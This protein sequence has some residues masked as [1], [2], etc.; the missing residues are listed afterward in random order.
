M[1]AG[2][3]LCIPVVDHVIVTRNADRYHSMFE[4]GTLPA[5]QE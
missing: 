4:R 1:L 2:K 3:I 5:I